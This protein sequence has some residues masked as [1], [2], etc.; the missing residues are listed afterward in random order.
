MERHSIGIGPVSVVWGVAFVLCLSAAAGAEGRAKEPARLLLHARLDG[1]AKLAVAAG[2]QKAGE[3]L[4]G[5][6]FVPG[7]KERQALI[8][9]GSG[10]G[11][12]IPLEGNYVPER[13]TLMFWF[14]PQH[15]LGGT[16]HEQHQLVACGKGQGVTVSLVSAPHQCHIAPYIF[17]KEGRRQV[18]AMVYKHLLAGK[19]YH[20]TFTWDISRGLLTLWMYG[21][22]EAD[23]VPQPLEIGPAPAEMLVGCKGAA[24]SDLRIY[25]R[26]LEGPDIRRIISFA[27]EEAMAGEGRTFYRQWVNVDAFR[28]QLVYQNTFDDESSLADWAM[29]GRGKARIVDGQLWLHTT[30]TGPEKPLG[31]LVYWNKHDFPAN[32][33]AE[34]DFTPTKLGGLCIV[35]FC[36]RGREG[37]DIFE[38]SLPARDAIFPRYHS[39]AINCYHISYFRNSSLRSPICNMRKNYGFYLV[40]VGPDFIPLEPGRK[41]HVTLI[42]DGDHIMFLTNGRLSIDFLDDGKTYGPVLGGGKIGLRQMGAT[43]PCLYD[44]FCVYEL[45]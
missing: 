36:A 33:V 15:N 25:D 7:R 32:F 17:D 39:G 24:I 8:S 38:P 29:E 26:A 12:R 1:D 6:A 43:W 40:A 28:G 21:R 27:P 42:K 31:H 9:T 2:G 10:A 18:N 16:P 20:L 35:F 4:S 34:W 45:K 11:V 3:L 14:Q 41:N 22:P 13:G 37:E 23:P 19:W 30:V 44:N 5:A